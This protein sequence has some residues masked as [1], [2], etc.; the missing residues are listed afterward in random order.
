MEGRAVVKAHLG[1]I[2]KILHMPR[3]VVRVKSD[4]DLS[5]FRD[6]AA[7]GIFLLKLYRHGVGI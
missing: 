7:A 6:N 5:K 4:L 2:D 3:R 1:Q